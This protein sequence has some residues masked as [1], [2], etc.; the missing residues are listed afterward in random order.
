MLLVVMGVAMSKL[1]CAFP[2][3][4]VRPGGYGETKAKNQIPSQSSKAPAWPAAQG[5]CAETPLHA[6][7]QPGA[8]CE[9]QGTGCIRHT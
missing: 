8:V 9:H 3:G 4:L 5:M 7:A 6:P 1:A 2:S